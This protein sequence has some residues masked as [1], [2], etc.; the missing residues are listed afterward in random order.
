MGGMVSKMVFA[1]ALVVFGISSEPGDEFTTNVI[2]STM[3][4]SPPSTGSIVTVQ[5]VRHESPV[6]P[7]ETNDQSV[8]T[9]KICAVVTFVCVE[10]PLAV[11]V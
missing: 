7:M 2:A 5:P 4:L 1:A 6:T 3:T 8:P 11:P 9:L 10:H